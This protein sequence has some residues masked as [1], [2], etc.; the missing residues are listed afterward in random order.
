MPVTI[1][2]DILAAALIG[3]REKLKEIDSRMSELR[4]R[5]GG[6]ASAESAGAAPVKPRLSAAARRRIGAAQRKR[7]AAA[8]ATSKTKSAGQQ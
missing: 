7:W 5:I 6:R 1:D 4:K 2:A 8:R 3:Y